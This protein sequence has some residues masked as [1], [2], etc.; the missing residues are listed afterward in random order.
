MLQLQ[1]SKQIELNRNRKKVFELRKKIESYKAKKEFFQFMRDHETRTNKLEKLKKSRIDLEKIK[2]A[3]KESFD[4]KKQKARFIIQTILGSVSVVN[5]LQIKLSKKKAGSTDF[6]RS[7]KEAISSIYDGF[8]LSRLV[9]LLNKRIKECETFVDRDL[10]NQYMGGKV[11]LSEVRAHLGSKKSYHI[12][13]EDFIDLQRSI[14]SAES[15]I[16]DT[17]VSK[18]RGEKRGRRGVSFDL[19]SNREMRI[20]TNMNHFKT[21]SQLARISQRGV[22]SHSI[23]F[24]GKYRGEGLSKK[25]SLD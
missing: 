14:V 11:K 3:K 12:K 4:L 19:N 2:Q 8:D 5:S 7:E 25:A 9:H 17:E 16:A 15:S 18:Q 21:S 20:P 1:K 6:G 10:I 23:D 24:V 13:Q 22:E